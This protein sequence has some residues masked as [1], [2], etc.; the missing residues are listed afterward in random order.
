M[1]RPL[2]E[3]S[4]GI[5]GGESAG[6]AVWRANPG[7]CYGWPLTG[8][9]SSE[10]CWRRGAAAPLGA[11]RRGA[12]EPRAVPSD[13]RALPRFRHRLV[14]FDCIGHGETGGDLK[15][16][17]L[18]SR[19]AQACA[20]IEALS[21]P[22]PFAV[23][24]GSMGGYTAVTLL[25]RY[26]IANLILVVPAMYAAEAFAVPFN[27]GFTEIIRRPNS[28]ES[29]DGWE[30][31]SD[32]QAATSRGRRARHRDPARRDPED[33]RVCPNAKERTLFVAPA[34]PHDHH[35][36][37]RHAPDQLDCVLG[38]MTGMLTA[39]GASGHGAVWVAP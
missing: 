3:G 8:A 35:R 28:W 9:P 31:L 25:P 12:V 7:A 21:L 15:Q 6:D 2:F 20:V 39:D 36:P 19:T 34:R 17:S 14:A 10:T 24:A 1:G 27:A 13:P 33:L 30:L 32:L 29:S 18:Q 37:T 16:S 23:L 38:L 11:A 22:Q 5:A 26:A 4:S